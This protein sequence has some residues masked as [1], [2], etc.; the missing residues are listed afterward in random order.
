MTKIF[1]SVDGAVKLFPAY[2]IKVWGCLRA[3]A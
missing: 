1:L 3:V 2:S